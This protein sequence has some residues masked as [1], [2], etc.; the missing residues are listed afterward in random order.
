MRFRHGWDL[1]REF[2]VVKD[3]N[4]ES[5]YRSYQILV[6]V[7]AMLKRGDSPETILEFITW[8]DGGYA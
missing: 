8:A 2:P 5:I 3:N 7:V 1:L 6:S 4:H